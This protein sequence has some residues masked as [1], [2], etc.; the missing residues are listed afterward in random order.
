VGTGALASSAAGAGADVKRYTLELGGVSQLSVALPPGVDEPRYLGRF[1]ANHSEMLEFAGQLA[2]SEMKFLVKRMLALRPGED[3]RDE[4]NREF[5][6]LSELHARYGAELGHSVPRALGVA[7]E[8]ATIIIEKLPG[9]NLESV[10]KRN[11]HLLSSRRAHHLL[12]Q[13]M[14]DL[15]R[16]LRR[17]HRA[18]GEGLGQFDAG[19]YQADLKMLLATCVGSGVSGATARAVLTSV[20]HAL[21]RAGRP[22]IPVARSHG[23]F[24]PQNVLVDG[25]HVA[26]VDFA[27]SRRGISVYGDLGSMLASL[28]MLGKYPIYPS[29]S[30]LSLRDA[31]LDGYAEARHRELILL[32]GLQFAVRMLSEMVQGR[33]ESFK[34]ALRIWRAEVKVRDLAQELAPPRPSRLHL[35]GR[36]AVQRAAT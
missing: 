18:T 3:A 27:S 32:H 9:E 21:G 2:G 23:D 28:V 14:R 34:R 7:P 36:G 33:R 29:M 8:M 25:E 30:V 10:L 12:E 11:A 20:E 31:F 4:V 1:R 15:G 26:V 13:V 17:F 5:G 35:P 6:I 24:L 22:S 16:W 19:V